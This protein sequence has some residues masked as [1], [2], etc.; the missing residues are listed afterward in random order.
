MRE[1]VQKA[2]AMPARDAVWA[3]RR[4]A[5]NPTIGLARQRFGPRHAIGSRRRARSPGPGRSFSYT[6]P[7]VDARQRVPPA[8]GEPA[9]H[10][11]ALAELPTL[12]AFRFRSLPGAATSS[13]RSRVERSAARGT[14]RP[15]FF[16]SPAAALLSRAAW[17]C[18]LR[19]RSDERRV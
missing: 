8:S 15:A 6:R 12:E 2:R 5:P 4:R 17:R 10:F 9:F 7:E 18:A 13:G 19:T 3:A 14:A 16:R 11:E 1:P